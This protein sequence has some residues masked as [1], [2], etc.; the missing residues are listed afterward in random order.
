MNDTGLTYCTSAI[1]T[2]YSIII[3]LTKF[4]YYTNNIIPYSL[5]S[6]DSQQLFV[7]LFLRRHQWLRTIKISYP[8]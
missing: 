1:Q 4:T 7:C 3:Y 6:G 5:F 8:D 2:C